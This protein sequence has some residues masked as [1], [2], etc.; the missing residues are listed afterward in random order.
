[1]AITNLPALRARMGDR[2]YYVATLTFDEGIRIIR[3]IDE[4][5]ERKEFKTWLQR[6][7][8]EERKEEIA[9][10]LLN[11]PQRFFNAVVTGLYGG[12][13]EWVPVELGESITAGDVEL[14]D[15]ESTAYGIVKLSGGEQIFAIDGQHRIAGIR[16]AVRQNAELGSEELTVIFVGHQMTDEGRERTRRLFTTLNKFAKPVSKA[17]LIALNDDD[18]FAVVTRNLIDNYQGL[19]SG[20]VPFTPTANIPGDDPTAI[21][22]VIGLY[23]VVRTVTA[24]GSAERKQLESGPINQK[25]VGEVSKLATD[26]WDALKRNVEAIGLTMASE[27]EAAVAGQYRTANGGNLLFRT[28]GLQSFA[29]ATRVLL[30]RGVAVEVAVRRLSRAPLDL[31]RPPWRGVL[32]NPSTHTMILKYSKLA[33][34]LL[35]HMVG[36]Q[37]NPARYPLARNYRTVL[38]EPHARLPRAV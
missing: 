13:P 6:V 12:E 4:I 30:D 18:A 23:D 28:V 24:S 11:Q 17:E 1:M 9:T 31:A 5:Q 37:L 22:T 33:E 10:Y 26:F 36:E 2:W 35:L 21:T 38:G 25:T 19:G 27:L 34:N 15:R 16:E 3:P 7:I 14:G 29:R 32:W 8:R 20:F